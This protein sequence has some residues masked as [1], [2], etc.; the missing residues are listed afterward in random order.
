MTL[1]EA[2]C[3]RTPLLTSDHPMFVLKI[4]DGYNAL[5]FPERNPAGLANRIEELWRSP[6]LYSRLSANALA[7][8]DAYLCPLKF[9]ALISGFLGATPSLALRQFS[10]A[11]GYPNYLR[12]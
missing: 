2:L 8:A 7:A 12:N 6:E 4:R 1:Y 10:L 11:S 3:T 5:V 9:D